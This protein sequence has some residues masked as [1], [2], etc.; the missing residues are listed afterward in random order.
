MGDHLDR[1]LGR[2]S[3]AGGVIGGDDFDVSAADGVGGS[4]GQG[5]G[6][7]SVG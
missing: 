1:S 2:R 6:L 7:A 4:D 5:P 3:D